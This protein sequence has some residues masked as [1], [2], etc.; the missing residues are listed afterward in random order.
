MVKYIPHS[1]GNVSQCTV[2]ISDA[3]LF[4]LLITPSTTEFKEE[5]YHIIDCYYLGHLTKG[6]FKEGG[7]SRKILDSQY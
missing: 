3:G 6:D 1:T 2:S 4:T 7:P 5:K